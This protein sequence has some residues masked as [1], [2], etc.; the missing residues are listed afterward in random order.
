LGIGFDI[1][2][3]MELRIGFDIFLT[4]HVMTV[5]ETKIFQICIFFWGR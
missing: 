1:L 5:K 4:K 3:T 2:L